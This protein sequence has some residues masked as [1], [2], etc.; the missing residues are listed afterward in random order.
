MLLEFVG[1][2]PAGLTAKDMILG[3]IGQVGVDGGVGHVVEYA[4]DPVRALSM[5][6]R[7]TICNMSIEW[8]AR[9]GMVAPDETTFAYME[10]REFAPKG[11]GLGSGTRRVAARSAATRTPRTTST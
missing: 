5:E 2:L 8:G 9:A 6:Q 11:D 10:G 1:E 7:M 3:A 4:G